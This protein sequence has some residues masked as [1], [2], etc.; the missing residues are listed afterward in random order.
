MR[1]NIYYL[2]MAI[3]IQSILLWY[4]LHYDYLPLVK[5]KVFKGVLIL[6]LVTSTIN[7]IACQLLRFQD[8]IVLNWIL[9]IAYFVCYFMSVW[10]IFK[11]GQMYVKNN[12]STKCARY[13]LLIPMIITLGIVVSSPW[14]HWFFYLDEAGVYH[15][16]ILHIIKVLIPFYYFGSLLIMRGDKEINSNRWDEAILTIACIVFIV[17]TLVNELFA[18]VLVMDAFACISVMMVY[19]T[20]ENPDFYISQTTHTYN[21]KACISYINEAI[22]DHRDIY[23]QGVSIDNVDSI[24]NQ[25]GSVKLRTGLEQVGRF[26]METFKDQYIFYVNNGQ[27]VFASTTQEDY[28]EMRKI[29]QTRFSDNFN[30]SEWEIFF[31]PSLFFVSDVKAFKNCENIFNALA[32]IS[33]NEVDCNEHGYFVLNREVL[34]RVYREQKIQQRLHEA[35]RDDEIQVYLQ[36]IYDT[37]KQRITG[38]EALARLFDEEL[39]F[40]PPNE[41]IAISERNGLINPVGMKVFETLCKYASS[42]DLEALGIEFLN[43]NISPV[44]CHDLHLSTR[45]KAMSDSYGLDFSLFNFEITETEDR[46][47][48]VFNEQLENIHAC[49]AH[50][51]LD[52][53]GTGSSNIVR[54]LNTPITTAKLDLSLVWDYFKGKN[55]ILEDVISVFNKQKLTIVAEGVEEQRM[56]NTLVQLG[57]EYLQGYYFSKP[58]PFD[59]FDSYIQEF[60]RKQSAL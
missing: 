11:Y 8:L 22:H 44:Q 36:P 1:W 30:K 24:R 40:I 17:G 45:L 10:W 34:A 41:F 50:I 23:V 14:T 47:V 32:M 20:I 21:Q 59:Q 19:M 51:S 54:L 58:I 52:D 29:I 37:K 18:N 39:G 27:F 5:N 3:V 48:A 28:E 56:V 26:L 35:L 33:R 16:G 13:V 25:Y 49:G 6:I 55:T 38:A 2:I 57:C 12:T 46:N 9:N 7:L 60:N 53:Y 4:Y 43:V 42:R 15:R 31:Q